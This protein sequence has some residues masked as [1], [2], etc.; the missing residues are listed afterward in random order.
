MIRTSTFSKW[1]FATA[2]LLLLVGETQLNAQT[3][4][5]PPQIICVGSERPYQVDY[6]ENGGQGTLGSTYTWSVISGPFA[7]TINTNQGPSGSSNRII[8]DWGASPPDTYILQV[9]ETNNGCPGTPQTLE[10][11]LQPEVLPDFAQIGPLCQN[12][13]P[14]ELPTT[15]IN[16]ITG[17]WS[18]ATISTVATGTTT[19]TFT[20]DAGQCAL[21]T[22]MNITIEDQVT[23]TFAAFG[24]YCQGAMPD[25]LPTTSLNGIT[26][27]WN[28]AINTSAPGTFDFTFTPNDPNQCGIPVTIQVVVTP[29]I[30][31]TF[32]PIGPLCQNSTAPGLPVTSINGITGTWSPSVI[33]ISTA[34]TSTYTFTPDAGQCA[35]SASIDITIT[36][37]VTPTFDPIGPLCQ[38]STA[39]GLPPTSLNSITGTW[40]GAISTSTPGDFTFTFTPNNP[41]QCALPTTLT[42][43]IDPQITPN[44][45]QIGPLCQNSPAP[46]LPPTSPNG[47]SGTWSPANI[48]TANTGT[49]TYTFTP[50]PGQCA[51]TFTMDIDIQDQVTPVFNAIGPFCLN[52]AAPTLPPLSNNGITGVWN[53]TVNTANQGTFDLTF[54]PDDP[55]QCGTATTVQYTVNALPTITV[56]DETICTGDSVELTANGAD[57]YNWSPSTGLSSTTGATVT[58]SPSATT[59][60]TVI[61]T[62][63]NGC[64][65]SADA[66]VTVNPLPT[67]SPI[68]HD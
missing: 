21:P 44:F 13:T 2:L 68:F 12:S 53:T 20:P 9:I 37:E 62:D 63:A 8:I 50:D 5:N 51:T 7:G 45:A 32:D 36:P 56:S 43:T 46:T 55:D 64:Q 11:I 16:G 34:G 54:T 1:L 59:T 52:D 65:N 24:P 41:S 38:N 58:A 57:T 17:T 48:S 6:L 29:L 22:T 60:Y 42:V 27:A 49:T 19:Y 30:T 23:P 66:T 15:S 39:P 4:H 61:G 31:P 26:G 3:I 28:E 47:I 25:E 33:N 18:P 14:P 67:T 40:S 35:N 10:I